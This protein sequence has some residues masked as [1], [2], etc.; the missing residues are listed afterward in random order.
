MSNKLGGKQGTAYLGTNA[1]QPPNWVFAFKD[2]TQYDVNN[3]SLGDLWLNQENE[4]VWVL[5]SLA[6]I[7]GSHGSLATWSKLESGAGLLTTLTGN[8]GGAV[9]PDSG[10]NINIVG[11]GTTITIAGNPGTNTLTAS[12]IGGGGGGA[13]SFPTDSGTATP[14]AGV[15]NIIAGTSIQNSGSSVEFTGIGNIVE[16][17]V[18]DANGNTI[19]G[20]NAGNATITGNNNSVLGKNSGTSL[21]S[22]SAN[23]FVGFQVGNVIG[24]GA[25]NTLI[26]NTAGSAYTTSESSNIVI[27]SVTAGTIGESNAL[28]IGAGTGTSTGQLNKSFISGIRGITPASADGIPVFVGSTGQ[29]GT[30]GTG[31]ATLVSTITGN[32][33]GAVSPLAGN[34]N[35]VG[36]GTTI[37]IT[38]NPGTHTLTVV[39]LGGGGGTLSELAG[40]TGFALPTAG[41][42]NIIADNASLNCGSSVLFSGSGD[43][44]T[45]NVTDTGNNVIIGK[46]SGNALLPTS[47][48]YNTIIG[49]GCGSNLFGGT[50]N[51]MVGGSVGQ[52]IT[53]GDRNVLIGIGAGFNY[54]STES[55]NIILG[56]NI[57][58]ILGESNVLRI[59]LGTGV[60]ADNLNKSFIQG[61]RGITPATADGIPVYIGSTGQLGTVGSGGATLVST[62]TGNSGGVV[63][64]TTGNINIVGDGTSVNVVGNPGTSTLTISASGSGVGAAFLAYVTTQYSITAATPTHVT[65]DTLTFNR[66]SGFNL[67]TSTFTAPTTGLYNFSCTV[68]YNFRSASSSG[69][70]I[71]LITSNHTYIPWYSLWT[72]M[73]WL[74]GPGGLV[75]QLT[76]GDSVYADMDI[77]DTATVE[78]YVIFASDILGS[79]SVGALGIT[80]Y[81]SGSL[82]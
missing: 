34:V 36:D 73:R 48:A 71:K 42:I 44:L 82:V 12:V 9:S 64:P 68:G 41:V 70:Y 79:T 37:Q 52:S 80:T 75:M 54:T 14:I 32:T 5:V 55:N 62:L 8:T 20:S 60:G 59:G 49:K 1:D 38:G 77:G 74:T 57:P 72:D 47:G 7:P 16:L 21:T 17:N 23:T 61:I 24:S 11:D 56:S 30:V 33:G 45:L 2:P 81:F 63:S 27:G 40:D 29:L 51:T 46:D 67:G 31:G 4:T 43:T 69:G 66:G 22:G 13:T 3:V 58:G 78:T 18:T 28:H 25:N 6:G 39:G 65:Y 15:I 76:V 26:G 19:I 50:D 10:A 35:I 53:D